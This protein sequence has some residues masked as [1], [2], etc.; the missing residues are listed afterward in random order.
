L[1]SIIQKKNILK[2]Q[3][4]DHACNNMGLFWH[5]NE[6]NE[7][8]DGELENMSPK[9]RQNLGELECEEVIIND[10]KGYGRVRTN[11]MK[12]LR[13]KYGDEMANR[14]LS[15][16]NKRVQKGYFSIL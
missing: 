1:V 16:V 4:P 3:I 9:L 14:A 5:N 7:E 15:R 10:K 2:D 6:T 12:V 13:A 8:E 11:M